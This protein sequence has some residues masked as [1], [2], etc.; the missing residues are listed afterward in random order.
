LL[1]ASLTELATPAPAPLATG[2]LPLL[3]PAVAQQVL[4]QT[5]TAVCLLGSSDYRI[6]YTNSAFEKLFPGRQLIGQTVAD[7]LPEVPQQGLAAL[8]DH[9]G[10][11]GGNFT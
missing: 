1:V 9:L 3:A 10:H 4:G 11:M 6:E 7:A 8:L 5:T 2:A